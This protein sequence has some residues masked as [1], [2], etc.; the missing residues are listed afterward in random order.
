[1][2][3]I[4]LNRQSLKHNYDYLDTL[5][6]N[7]NIQW[8]VVS[9]LLCGDMVFLKETMRLGIKQF[10]DSRMTNIKA[11]KKIDPS[12]ETVYIKPPASLAVKEV[13]QY[14]DISFNTE[15]ATLK[16]L[17]K[18]ASLNGKVH[19]VIIMVEL[20]ELREGVLRNELLKLYEK[21][22]TLPYIEVVGLGTNFACLSGVLPDHDKLNQL[23]LYREL[24]A[25]KYQ[26]KIP[27]VSG[28]SSVTI[29]LLLE[30]TLPDGI[31][32]FRIG[33]TLFFG[34][35]VYHSSPLLEMKQDVFS[36]HTEIIELEEKPIV[37]EG[38][39]GNNLE[40][41][42][43]E[44]SEED[45]GK[46]TIRAIL[47]LGLLDVEYAHIFPEDTS[48]SCTGASSDMLIVDLGNNPAKYKV[49]DIISFSMDYMGAFRLMN[50]KY[51]RKQV[52]I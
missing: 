39:L 16:K 45:K 34:T 47:D 18:E 28:G 46:T 14:A 11:I 2:A 32:H 30:N 19:K 25:A 9:K 4:T 22:I 12:V 42:T 44:Y 7:H 31:N 21:A 50:S 10:C 43:P 38:L 3:Y 48:I 49:G 15:F 23:A 26:K 13:V 1:M 6:K 20:G 36:L 37:P 27:Y 5:F 52:V 40:G 17:S 35:D 33:E 41:N 29:P 51:V 8:S 24:I